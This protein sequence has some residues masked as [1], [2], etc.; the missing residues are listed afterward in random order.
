ML[1][2]EVQY[3]QHSVKRELTILLQNYSLLALLTDFCCSCSSL[4]EVTMCLVDKTVSDLGDR[5]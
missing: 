5:F 4:M 1:I 2:G 3:V